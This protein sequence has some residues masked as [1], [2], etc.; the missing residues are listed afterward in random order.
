VSQNIWAILINMHDLV[1][2]CHTGRAYVEIPKN[3]GRWGPTARM[4]RG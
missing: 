3:W 4:G 1:A 2:V